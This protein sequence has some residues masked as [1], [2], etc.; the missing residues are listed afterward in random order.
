MSYFATTWA[1]QQTDLAPTQ[2]LVLLALAD[3]HTETFGCF[4]SIEVLAEKT[5]L[6]RRT[7]IRCIDDLVEKSVINKRTRRTKTHQSS[8]FYTFNFTA[9]KP[10]VEPE[11]ECHHGTQQSVTVT[12][13]LEKDNYTNTSNIQNP[14]DSGKAAQSKAELKVFWDE[15]VGMLMAMGLAEPQAKSFTGRCLK[16]AHGNTQEILRAME[17]AVQ[18]ATRDPIPYVVA[19]LGGKTNSRA[20]KQK[21]WDD[22]LAQFAAT[23]DDAQGSDHTD[24]GLLSTLNG[25][26]PQDLF[27]DGISSS[28]QVPANSAGAT[29]K[30]KRGYLSQI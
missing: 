20:Q 5:C 11:A 3:F 25:E 17:A 2:K 1:W 13:E 19:I 22:A 23:P 24:H 29:G 16:I 26:G 30:P 9:L 8:N 7:V 12:P 15:A 18:A 6:S 10:P 4:P 21:E 27:G 28:L 14:S